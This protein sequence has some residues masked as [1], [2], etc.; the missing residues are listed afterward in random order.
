MMAAVLRTVL[1][2]IAGI[3]VFPS[4]LPAQEGVAAR[5][6][7]R[8]RRD[9]RREAVAGQ[10]PRTGALAERERLEG[11]LRIALARAVRE[12]LSL[13]N[14]QATRLMDVNRRFGDDRLR[15]TRDEL[16]I[17]RDLR[18]AIATG[19]SARSPETGRLLDGLL[20][21][22]RQRLELQQKEQTEL[23]E[24]LTPEQRARYIGM[25]E[26]LRRRIQARADSARGTDD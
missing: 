6:G 1:C 4:I 13:S 22:Q 18:Q 9:A 19:D 23:S 12:R 11:A 20:D 8:A 25:M 2:A 5:E 21:V 17:R 14:Q 26:Q 24:F 10:P 7:A 15:L 3:V 16:R